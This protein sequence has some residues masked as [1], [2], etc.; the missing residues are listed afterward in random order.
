[1]S[2][3]SKKSTVS[4]ILKWIVAAI[5]CLLGLK[6]VVA[7]ATF[8]STGLAIATVAFWGAVIL[9]VGGGAAFLGYKL[10]KK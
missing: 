4:S 2:Q 9:A 10:L 3:K 7:V 6:V 5:C 1:M 8:I